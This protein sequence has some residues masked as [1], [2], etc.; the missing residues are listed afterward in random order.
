MKRRNFLKIPALGGLAF[1]MRGIPIRAYAQS[2]LLNAVAKQTQANGRVL[3]LIQLNGGNDGINTIVPLDQYS[4]LSAVRSNVLVDESK[5]LSLSGVQNTGMHPAMSA[6]RGMYNDGLVNI[7]QAAGY[8]QP[9]FSHFRSTDIWTTGSNADEYLT[10]G[11]MGRYLDAMYPGYPTG[12]PN[13]DTP[14]PLAIQIGTGMSTMLQGPSINMGYAIANVNSFYDLVNNS[15]GTAPNTAAGHELTFIRNIAQQ[16]QGYTAVIQQATQ[17]ATNLGPYPSNNS[18][19]DQLKIVAQLIAGGLQ[20]SIYVVSLG[21]FDTHANQVEG[22][23][24]TSGPHAA[25][26]KLLSDAVS[27][28]FTDLRMQ[29]NDQRVTAMTFSE[30]GR[31]IKSNNSGG[32]DHG[33]AA[34]LMV[35]GPNVNPRIIGHNPVIPPQT[36]VEDNI[37][38][39]FDY[40][41]VYASV[42]K[43]WFGVTPQAVDDILLHDYPT[44][45]I[46]KGAIATEVQ[47]ATIAV[48]SDDMLGQNY[49]NPFSR[50]TTVSFNSK[51]GTV[52]LQVFDISGRL[53]KTVLEENF[54]PGRHETTIDRAGLAAGNYMYRLTNGSD[55]SI[56]KMIVI[57]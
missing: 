11:W 45:P 15:V 36:T 53:V 54:A 23:G 35:F 27:A 7:V 3:V 31:R 49:P 56:K 55:Q 12:F 29:G 9:N 48:A 2:P 16:S 21:G 41:Q 44:L 34:P 5:I 43:D 22:T 51:G 8:A 47:G 28:F 38:M 10:T 20:T 57:D 25:L 24:N 13:V 14:D 26:L 40:R 52:T 37:P 17:S 1:M 50:N 6:I 46:F 39:Q 42:L 18:L 33:T 4:A 19:A 32:T 30:F